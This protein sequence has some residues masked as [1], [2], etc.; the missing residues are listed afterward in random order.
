M[1]EQEK[2]DELFQ[3]IVKIIG[4]SS[5]VLADRTGLIIRSIGYAKEFLDDLAGASAGIVGC[6]IE[7]GKFMEKKVKR[8]IIDYENG[9]KTYFFGFEHHVILFE[10]NDFDQNIKDNEKIKDLLKQIEE[11]PPNLDNFEEFMMSEKE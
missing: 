3:E 8:V 11:I 10:A 1:K 7:S 4:K 9:T 6:A 2:L 5:V